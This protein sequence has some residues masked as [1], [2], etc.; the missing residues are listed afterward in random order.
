MLKKFNLPVTLENS[1]LIRMF[2]VLFS[3]IINSYFD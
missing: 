1:P 2:P 3:G